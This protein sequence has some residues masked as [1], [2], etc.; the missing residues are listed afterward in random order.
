VQ[1]KA[2]TH[3]RLNAA[4]AVE[5][6]QVAPSVV[7]AIELTGSERLAVSAKWQAAGDDGEVG[8]AHAYEVRWSE[9][10]INTPEEWSAARQLEVESISGVTG[11]NAEIIARIV[12]FGFNDSGFLAVRARDNVGNLGPVGEAVEFR[13]EPVTIVGHY[14]PEHTTELQLSGSWGV[15]E[16]SD[17]RGLVFSDSP[18]GNYLPNQDIAILLPI[19]HVES[20]GY[21]LAF[22]SKADLERGYDFGRIEV[23]INGQGDWKLIKRVTDQFDWRSFHLDLDSFVRGANSFQLRFRLISDAEFE[24][25]GWWM[26]DISLIRNE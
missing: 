3:G 18:A 22:E 11:N 4:A 15:E 21:A 8:R 23:Q 26:N 2:L 17:R 13:V 7:R 10:S 19:V 6:D 14:Q 9:R 24:H 1:G 16:L 20:S 12:G 25:G 5:V